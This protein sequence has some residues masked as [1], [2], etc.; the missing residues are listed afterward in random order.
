LV[1]A[2]GAALLVLVMMAVLGRPLLEKVRTVA[3][4]AVIRSAQ[5]DPER[6][7]RLLH[8][9][10]IQTVI[11]LRTE[12]DDDLLP[13]ERRDIC[14]RHGIGYTA[15]RG[16]SDALPT[17]GMVTALVRAWNEAP[18]PIL[19]HCLAGSDRTG[20]AAAMFEL[21]DGRPMAAALRQLSWRTLH[22]CRR[23]RC[24]LHGYFELYEK[25]LEEKGIEHEVGHFREWNLTH[26]YPP[27]Y[28]RVVEVLEVPDQAAAGESVRVRVRVSNTSGEDWVMRDDPRRGIRFGVRLLGPLAT[29]SGWDEGEEEAFFHHH[30]LAAQDLARVGVEDGVWPASETRTLDLALVMP[31]Q[32]GRYLLALDMVDELVTWFYVQATPAAYH[33]IEVLPGS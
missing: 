20:L 13:N 3:G 15:V 26:Y 32:P 14:V 24:P 33:V 11:S 1:I 8:E 31:E 29:F 21:L 7:E 19:V 5:L 18:R 30:R 9:R 22:L 23:S 4:G 25:H 27:P 12:D 16:R 17:V 2:V 28:S 10:G 6:F